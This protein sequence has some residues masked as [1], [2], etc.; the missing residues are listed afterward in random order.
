MKANLLFLLPTT[1]LISTTT[2]SFLNDA[3][4]Q[5]G[6]T[7]EQQIQCYALPY[8]A[9]GFLTH[10]LT[11]YTAFMLTIGRSPWR[12][13]RLTHWK[14]DLTCALI[15][16]PLTIAPVVVTMVRCRSRWIFYLLATWKLS[17]TL[18][19]VGTTI[20]TCM[21]VR[22]GVNRLEYEMGR[23]Q[24]VM[25]PGEAPTNKAY[26]GSFW[27]TVLLLLLYA[28]GTIIGFIALVVLVKEAWYEMPL[29][30][31]LSEGAIGLFVGLAAIGFLLGAFC[32]PESWVGSGLIG[33]LIVSI[34]IFCA[35]AVIYSDWA[36]AV[37]ADN[38]VGVPDGN[39]VKVTVLYWTYFAAKRLPMLSY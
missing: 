6:Q 27:R 14:F 36:L 4:P 1:L 19:L 3:L 16:L 10:L 15:G 18:M 29:L 34:I 32:W 17:L 28:V 22:R 20:T 23:Y 33:A 30:Q 5:P 9:I 12:W 7:V 38:I 24:A 37:I 26:Q 13:T 25:Q 39:N 35:G 8:G 2:A 11:Y 31:H 21:C